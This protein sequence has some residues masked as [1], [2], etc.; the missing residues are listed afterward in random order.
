MKIDISVPRERI[1]SATSRPN[2][3][4]V[5]SVR[6]GTTISTR[7][8]GGSIARSVGQARVTAAHPRRVRSR[9]PTPGE[10]AGVDPVGYE[11][12]IKGRLS[13]TVTESFEDFTASVKPA[14]TVIRGELRD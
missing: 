2:P 3:T 10:G 12:R 4:I 9:H 14:E 7:W 6:T 13:D 11:F 8:G 5:S 1:A